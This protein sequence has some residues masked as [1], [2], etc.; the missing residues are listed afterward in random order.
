MVK[1]K[2]NDKLDLQLLFSCVL[3]SRKK[4]DH[5]IKLFLQLLFSFFPANSQTV[6]V[7]RKGTV[8]YQKETLMEEESTTSKS[9]NDVLISLDRPSK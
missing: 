5:I 4:L 6:Y 8:K 2:H 1:K 3:F 9:K 7:Y